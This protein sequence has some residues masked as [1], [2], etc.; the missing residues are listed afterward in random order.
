MTQPID[1]AQT[2]VVSPLAK[3][4]PTDP[5]LAAALTQYNAA[6]TSQQ[7]TWATNYLKAVAKVTFSNG[8]PVVPRGQ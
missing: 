8:T 1:A 7:N 5:A 4:A 6:S 2:F 3:A